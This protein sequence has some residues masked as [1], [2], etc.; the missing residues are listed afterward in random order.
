MP[1]SWT[2][3]RWGRRLTVPLALTSALTM[4]LSGAAWAEAVEPPT[5]LTTGTPGDIAAGANAVDNQAFFNVQ[6][7][8]SPR[9]MTFNFVTTPLSLAIPSPSLVV[10]GVDG[11][12]HQFLSPI[13]T[14]FTHTTDP[15]GWSSPAGSVVW[16]P[17]KK[18]YHLVFHTA[19]ASAI[20]AG[21]PFSN[22]TTTGTVS[23]D[24]WFS[25]HPGGGQDPSDW[26]GQKNYWIQ[27]LGTA[28][29][30]GTVKFPDSA[31]PVRVNDW[32][33]EQETEY[34]TYELGPG[35][36]PPSGVRHIGYDYGE[37]SNPDGST[38]TMQVLPEKDGVW[39]GILTHTSASGK[40]TSCEPSGPGQV[41]LA[42]WATEPVSRMRYPRTVRVQCTGRSVTWHTTE[43][44]TQV[45][46]FSLATS[47]FLTTDSSAHT[48]VPGSVGVMQHL[49]DAG[50][51]GQTPGS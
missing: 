27:S 29:V 18:A 5:P 21:N 26:D 19:I 43:A 16:V 46:Y 4:A 36:W 8:H 6:D 3:R 1:K 37:S 30:T 39:R 51:F 50:S 20:P 48:D 25:G 42:D 13:P 15:A 28:K 31:T 2:P 22:G 35:P 34:G 45:P 33:G 7:F 17:E 38:D 10:L 11:A 47:G 24:L 12:G 23:A 41:K 44:Q 9:K 32:P 14:A 40:V 49:R